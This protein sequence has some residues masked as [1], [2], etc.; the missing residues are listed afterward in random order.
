MKRTWVLAVFLLAAL[1]LRASAFFR[2]V[3]DWDESLYLL[4]ARSIL[5][6]NVPY[7]VVWDHKPP[8]IYFVFASV[9]FVFGDSIPAL[10]ILTSVVVGVTSYM[11]YCLG[12][13]LNKE[14]R[15]PGLMAGGLYVVYS[16]SSAMRGLASNTEL[17]YTLFTVCAFLVLFAS[18]SRR[19]GL[20]AGLLLGLGFQIKYHVAFDFL[21]ALLI[22]GG[23]I[24][25]EKPREPRLWAILRQW[26]LMILGFLLPFLAV[27]SYFVIGGHFQEYVHSTFV[28][29]LIYVTDGQ[30]DIVDAIRALRDQ[31]IAHPLLWLSS[32]V[33]GLSLILA[34]RDIAE[35]RDKFFILTW[36]VAGFLGVLATRRLWDHDFL[37]ILPAMCLLASYAVDEVLRLDMTKLQKAFVL[38][39][40]LLST[41]MLKPIHANIGKTVSSAYERYIE[42]TDEWKD[43]ALLIAEYLDGRTESSDFIYIVD[44]Q[45]V[46]YFL[47]HAQCPTRYPFPDHLTS[48]ELARM[49]G[50]DPVAELHTIMSKA[51][52]Y[53]VRRRHTDTSSSLLYSTLDEYLA[54]EYI[55]ETSFYDRHEWDGVEVDLYRLKTRTEAPGRSS[56][57]SRDV[58]QWGVNKPALPSR[59]AP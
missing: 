31:L 14:S 27:I 23:Q 40:A 56:L 59:I 47:A 17:F 52:L 42:G 48:P 16:S 19:K 13:A 58:I 9:L 37:Q 2:S 21:A 33:S 53:V 15:A 18:R 20:L 54:T 55:Y 57:I 51:P 29:N 46:I 35:E 10:R 30:I 43:A 36:L 1:I 24:L 32:S 7:T 41:S 38:S 12:V 4:M 26:M 8:G 45:P 49:A 28:A 34:R 50:I 44:H 39:V 3:V 25:L 5:E 22:A 6:G 11:L